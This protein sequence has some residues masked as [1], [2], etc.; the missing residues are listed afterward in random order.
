MAVSGAINLT[1]DAAIN[2]VNEAVSF[3]G[4]GLVNES[5]GE[6][7]FAPGREGDVHRIIHPA[8]HHDFQTRTVWTF[9]EDMGC[10][11]LEG[12]ASTQIVG[13]LGEGALAPVDP[14]VRPQIRPVH[15][16]G[17]TSQ[18]LALMPF[19]PLIGDA[20]VVGIGK[21]PNAGR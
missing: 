4:F 19:I 21:L 3:P 9:P 1:V 7:S 16:V 11:A 15:V 18:G 12:F 5:R 6:E 17:A 14:A 10:A 20:I 13:L 2:G 8:G